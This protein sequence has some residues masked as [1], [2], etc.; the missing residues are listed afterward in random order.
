MSSVRH[1]FSGFAAEANL[2]STFARRQ[3]LSRTPSC[4]KHQTL[5]IPVF[6]MLY[7]QSGM[8]I[9]MVEASQWN[10]PASHPPL[11]IVQ[12]ALSIPFDAL[13]FLFI[14]NV[15]PSGSKENAVLL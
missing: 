2:C 3:L 14:G 6:N 12:N 4:W 10:E 13:S 5:M 7:I 11:N 1:I 8:L 9:A 15:Q